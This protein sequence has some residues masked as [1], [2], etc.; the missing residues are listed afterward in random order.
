MKKRLVGVAAAALM[1]VSG[2][3]A[4]EPEGWKVEVTPYAWLAGLEGDVTIKGHKA[5]FD[6]S[7]SDMLDYV[8][9]AGSLLTV[10]QYDRYLVWGQVDYFGLSTDALDIDDQPDHGELDTT[11]VLTEVAAGYQ[12]DGWMEGQTFD[13]LLGARLLHMESDLEIYGVGKSSKDS[14]IWN[15]IAVVRPS[16]PLFPSKITG[17]RFNPTLAIGGGGGNTK[18]TYELAPQI[19]YAI[20]DSVAVRFG[21]RRVG[22]QFNGSGDNELNFDMAGLMLGLGV[23]F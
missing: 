2:A 11:M 17:L 4:A 8:E 10:V 12:V 16:I 18:L 7:F 20:N 23:M 5:E 22:Y 1:A 3:L 19:E 13:L 14:D 9:M 15:P 6:K 21:Y